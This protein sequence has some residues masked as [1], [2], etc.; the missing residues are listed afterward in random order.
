MSGEGADTLSDVSRDMATGVGNVVQAMDIEDARRL[1][2]LLWI[3]GGRPRGCMVILLEPH[4]TDV[5][6]RVSSLM[7]S[8]GI[9]S[10]VY[11]VDDVV[12]EL[13]PR[14]ADRFRSVICDDM[15]TQSH[16]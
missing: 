16:A 5:I 6:S 12:C 8:V 11:I 10:D 9:P 14:D 1:L 2:H 15:L 13:R 3:Y 4:H 7:D